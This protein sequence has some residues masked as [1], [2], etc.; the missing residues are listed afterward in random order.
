[1]FLIFAGEIAELNLAL[2]LVRGRM[3]LIDGPRAAPKDPGRHRVGQLQGT[4]RVA[5]R[6]SELILGSRGAIFL[7][8]IFHECGE[9]F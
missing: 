2:A 5:P 1:M 9:V 8:E 3:Q 6:G 7:R 4:R